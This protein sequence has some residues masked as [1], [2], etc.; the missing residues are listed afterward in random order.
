MEPSAATPNPL[1]APEE[2]GNRTAA[3]S[4]SY[5]KAFQTIIS[6]AILIAT[7]F[8]LWTPAS[9]FTNSL[10]EKMNLAF[11]PQPANPN[12]A[13]LPTPTARPVP[14]IGIVSGHWGNDSGAVCQDGLTEADVNLKIATLVQQNLVSEGYE[15][16]LL[17][18]FDHKLLGYQALMLVSIHNDSCDYINDEATGFKVSAAKSNVF[19][20]KAS[21]LTACLVDRYGSITGMRFHYNSITPDMTEYHA[22]EEIN[23]NTTAGIIETGFLNLDRQILTEQS[24][25]VAE[26]VTEGILC[27]VRNENVVPTPISANP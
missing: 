14:R 3:P 22:F 2:A 8:T 6:V 4:M 15:V 23:T 13:G 17:K 12:Q 25:L 1:T 26:G 5:F 10:T 24:E 19:P 7:L 11:E 21:R 9:L 27:Y 16:D 18:E 20:E